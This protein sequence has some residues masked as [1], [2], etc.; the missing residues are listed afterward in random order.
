MKREW[1]NVKKQGVDGVFYNEGSIEETLI[2]H[3]S[4]KSDARG[5]LTH[6]FVSATGGEYEIRATYTGSNNQSFVS[7]VMFYVS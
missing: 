5:E 2:E 4:A 7:S 1:K 6:T 3:T